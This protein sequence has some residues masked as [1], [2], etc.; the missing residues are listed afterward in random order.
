MI[1]KIV[2][3]LMITA[4]LPTVSFVKA[5]QPTKIWRVGLSHVGLDHV[6][7]SLEPLRQELKK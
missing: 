1:R 6:P 2:I 4:L 3:C 5:Q 7:P